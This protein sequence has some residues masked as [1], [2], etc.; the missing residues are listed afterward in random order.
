M[1]KVLRRSFKLGPYRMAFGAEPV[2][3]P[4][5]ILLQKMYTPLG[6]LG[7]EKLSTDA[8]IEAAESYGYDGQYDI[9]HRLEE[10]TEDD[11]I[12]PLRAYVS[13]RLSVLRRPSN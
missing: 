6:A 8:L 12:V 2:F 1:Q 13:F 4:E 5:S 7:I 11:Y 3:D 9:A 10:G